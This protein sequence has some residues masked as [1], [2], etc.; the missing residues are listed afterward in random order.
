MG[1][2]LDPD[3]S[4]SETANRTIAGF[5]IP[6]IS[7]H[8]ARMGNDGGMEDMKGLINR[9]KARIP[10]LGEDVPPLRNMLGDHIIDQGHGSLDLINPFS[11][12]TVN[13]DTLMA[14][15]DQI[16]HG[17]TAPRSLKNGVEL[18]NYQSSSGQT[19]Y[20]R[21][22]ELS[23]SVVIKGSTL[24]RALRKLMKSRKYQMLPYDSVDGVDRSPRTRL[25]QTLLN[26]YRA[27]AFDQMVREFPEVRHRDTIHKMIKG[28]RRAGRDYEDLLGLIE[29]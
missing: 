5:M 20:D 29:D 1:L 17:F 18:R 12:S 28:R 13:D 7:A 19:A 26:K 24:K 9:L 21:W 4:A 10:G 2:L 25:I 8:I 3:K 15:F 22:Q 6:N 16:G 27:K 23:G 14:E 11:H